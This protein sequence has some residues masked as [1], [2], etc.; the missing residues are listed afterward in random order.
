LGEGGGATNGLQNQ[1]GGKKS[2]P[3][4]NKCNLGRNGEK[5]SGRSLQLVFLS[6]YA[7]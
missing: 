2:W 3:W 7:P 1:V 5:P 4:E 6:S